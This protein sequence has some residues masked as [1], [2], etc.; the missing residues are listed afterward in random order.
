MDRIISDMFLA[1]FEVIIWLF[2]FEPI[3]FFMLF[4][5]FINFQNINKLVSQYFQWYFFK[6]HYV[7]MILMYLMCLNLMQLTLRFAAQIG[8][9]WATGLFSV[10][11]DKIAVIL[12]NLFYG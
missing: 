6:C 12:D 8:L 1:F 11:L 3:S 5:F 2:F 4:F 10:S 9:S 7:Q